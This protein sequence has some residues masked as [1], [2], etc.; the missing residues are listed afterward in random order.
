MNRLQSTRSLLTATLLAASLVGVACNGTPSTNAPTNT[1]S[2]ATPA[3]ENKQQ[4]GLT[5]SSAPTPPGGVVAPGS[6]DGPL[7]KGATARVQG[8]VINL[9]CYRDNPSMTPDNLDQ[10]S[11]DAAADSKALVFLGSDGI[12]YVPEIAAEMSVEY[13]TFIGEDVNIDGN[14][15]ADAPNLAW[16]GVTVKKMEVIRVR[17]RNITPAVSGTA[18]A[19]TPAATNAAPTKKN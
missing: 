15:H 18:P 2:A 9:A 14:I 5:G 17:K 10:C 19:G 12:V 1:N 6:P 16:P 4:P 8:R 13:K 3:P 7:T 11:R